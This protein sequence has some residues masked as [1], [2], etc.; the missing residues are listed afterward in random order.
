MVAIGIA[1]AETAKVVVGADKDHPVV[2]S[3][4]PNTK[5][6]AKKQKES[7][8]KT[9]VK[10]K[11]TVASKPK[12]RDDGDGEI[13]DVAVEGDLPCEKKDEKKDE[14]KGSSVKQPV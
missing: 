1:A 7:T 14:K 11:K 10:G 8:A 13:S 6:T 2:V 5:T 9:V 12:G 3:S 4:G